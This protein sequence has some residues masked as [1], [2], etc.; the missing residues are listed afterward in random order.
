MMGC[1]T[2]PLKVAAFLVLLLALAAGWFFRTEIEAFARRQ[3]GMAPAPSRVG[4]AEPG[5]AD[6]ARAR[7]DSLGRSGIDSVVVTAAEMASLVQE[8]LRRVAAGSPDSIAVELDD[9]ELTVRARVSTEPIPAAIREILRGAIGAREQVELSGPLS[10]R[11]AGLG[12][13]EVERVRVRGLPVPRDLMERLVGE[14]L[15]RTSGPSVTFSVPGEV[16]GIRATRGGVI[17]YGGG[18]R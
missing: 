5:G 16:T 6:R 17:L 4:W 18:R 2:F 15:P 8:E 1:L 10:L 12:E 13:F 3:L 9:R 14:Y 7:L 11:R